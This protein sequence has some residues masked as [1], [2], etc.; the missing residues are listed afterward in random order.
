MASGVYGGCLVSRETLI[1]QHGGKL[2]VIDISPTVQNTKG[3]EKAAIETRR[4]QPDQSENSPM[5][6]G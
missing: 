3:R 4:L 2:S 1:S 6:V 5:H